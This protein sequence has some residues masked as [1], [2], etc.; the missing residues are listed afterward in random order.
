MRETVLEELVRNKTFIEMCNS[1][2]SHAIRHDQHNKEK[3]TSHVNSSNQATG[4]N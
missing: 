3:V 1:L 4:T 2:K